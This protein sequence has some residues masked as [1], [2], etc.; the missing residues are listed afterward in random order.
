MDKWLLHVETED[1]ESALCRFLI[2]LDELRAR[3]APHKYSNLEVADEGHLWF[4]VD[5]PKVAIEVLGFPF[6]FK[7]IKKPSIAVSLPRESQK[8]DLSLARRLNV[9]AGTILKAKAFAG[10]STH[11]EILGAYA[12]NK[13]PPL[14]LVWNLNGM[15][16][17]KEA[18][19]FFSYLGL[20]FPVTQT[21]VSEAEHLIRN[22]VSRLEEE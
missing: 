9:A 15:L 14:H 13:Q 19:V 16:E 17:A 20:I 21:T 7:E 5:S 1:C 6:G 2:A 4:N 18:N 3:L 10:F 8:I 12:L 22:V 11:N